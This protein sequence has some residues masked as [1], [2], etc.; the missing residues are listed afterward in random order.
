[1]RERRPVPAPWRRRTA[2]AVAVAVAVAGLAVGPRLAL[3][4][5]LDTATASG[6]WTVTTETLQ[7]PS[8]LTSGGCLLGTV[9]LTWNASPTTWAEGYQVRWS[10]SN[11]GP[12]NLGPLTTALTTRAV[13][14]LSALTT[15]Y[16]VV[17]AYR[18]AWFSAN[19]NQHSAT[20]LV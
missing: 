6:A 2:P 17:R 9:T 4:A 18:G 14:G 7:P 5:Y 3:A 11:G 20:C 16:F 15:Y 1:M 8:G 19:S 12:Y 13:T 10:T